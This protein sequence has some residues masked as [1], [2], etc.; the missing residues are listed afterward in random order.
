ML[1][2]LIAR[3]GSVRDAECEYRDAEYEYRDAEYEYRDAEYEYRDAEYEYEYE[4]NG[5]R[6][7]CI[8]RE[9]A[10]LSSL[11]TN[12]TRVP[13]LVPPFFA[14]TAFLWHGRQLNS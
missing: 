3:S 11:L 7:P 10:S 2:R 13:P 12:Q 5:P 9:F 8:E 6:E 14:L 4:S 1:T